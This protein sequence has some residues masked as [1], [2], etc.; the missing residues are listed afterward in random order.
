METFFLILIWSFRVETL[1]SSLFTADSGSVQSL[2]IVP[3]HLK[4]SF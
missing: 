1:K 4:S 3:F 2:T